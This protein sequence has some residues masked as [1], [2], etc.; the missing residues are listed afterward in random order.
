[1]LGPFFLLLLAA[2]TTAAQDTYRV[3]APAPAGFDRAAAQRDTLA[4]LE[5]LITLDTQN[6]PGN[7]ILTANY[8]DAQL[9]G[10]P[11]I[12]TH[13]LDP[14][15]GRA[16]FVARLRA[17]TPSKRA[18]LV[19]GHM[20]VVGADTTKWITPPFKPTKRDGYLY[21]RGAIDDKGM[22]A[23]TVV[24]MRQLAARREAL[25]RDIIL[26]ATAAEEGG[27]QGIERV[28]SQHFDLIKDAEFAMNE[29]GR[30][31]VRNGRVYA[32]NIQITE[33]LS[34]VVVA[35]AKGT[36]GHGSVPLPDNAIAALSRALARVHESKPPVRMN[37]TTRE[38]FARLAKV[39]EHDAMRQAMET[40][41]TARDQ[42]T[43][44][45]AGEVLSA[46][47]LHNAVLRTGVSLTMIDGGIRSN[48]IPSDATATLNVRVLPDGDIRADVAEMN[49]I[50]GEKGVTFELK[51]QPQKAP[52]VSPPTTA[53]FQAM[54][55]AGKAM[56]PEAIVIPFMSTGGTDGA[57]LRE[58][59]IP[60][61]GILPMPLPMEDELRMHGDNERVP[62][63]ALGW[64]AE[65]LYRVLH[66]MGTRP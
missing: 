14:G 39:E 58:H 49:R 47:P 48:V 54:D 37:P 11:G 57:V 3:A 27:D 30:I 35:T 44:D 13:I 52:P 64:A 20:D 8:L 9:R 2:A 66:L 10:I 53:L 28:V 15:D 43:I 61:Y 42:A 63:D 26:L 34:Y 19:M 45:K 41:A 24:V 46:E 6:P 4:H 29:G 7:E 22:L 21:G 50:G 51:G 60:T 18:V 1:M 17:T 62:I 23:A 16:N 36:G 31:R 65:Y 32:I 25:D 40:I 38:Y 56:A 55:A 33:K 12:Q 5:Q 59:G